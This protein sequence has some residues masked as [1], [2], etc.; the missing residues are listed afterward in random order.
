[1]PGTLISLEEWN[2]LRLAGPVIGIDEAGRGA[3]AGPV[4]V[5]AAVLVNTIPA[6]LVASIRDSKRLRPAKRREVSALLKFY[7]PYGIGAA[8]AREIDDLGLARAVALAAGR[9]LSGVMF[10]LNEPPQAILLDGNSTNWRKLEPTLNVVGCPYYYLQKADDLTK[11]VGAA[12]IIA[13]AYRDAEMTV[14]AVEYDNWG[15]ERNY[16][17]G[18]PE[19]EEA[20]SLYGICLLHRRSFKPMWQ[21]VPVHERMDYKARQW[22]EQGNPG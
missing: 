16:G 7:C 11:V 8:T 18:T 20:L 5:G 2:D 12:S 15:F 4:V 10:W 21:W 19:H 3:W 22:R 13:K 9:A 6:S 17:Y 14:S 1:M